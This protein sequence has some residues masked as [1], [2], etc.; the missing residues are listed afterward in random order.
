M[1]CDDGRDDGCD[2]GKNVGSENCSSD[3]SDVCR[4]QLLTLHISLQLS[5]IS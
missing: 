1:G 3:G 2:D 5:C 4:V